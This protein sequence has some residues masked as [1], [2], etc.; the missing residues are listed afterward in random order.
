MLYD[1]FINAMS[2]VGYPYM[3]MSKATFTSLGFCCLCYVYLCP[4]ANKVIQYSV[5][6]SS[7][8]YKHIAKAVIWQ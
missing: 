5:Q 8:A 3:Y 7:I 4:C 1:K 6:F 2:C